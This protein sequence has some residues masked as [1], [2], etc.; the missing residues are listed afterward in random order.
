MLAITKKNSL[1]LSPLFELN[2][3]PFNDPTAPSLSVQDPCNLVKTCT[4]LVKIHKIFVSKN[5]TSYLVVLT[6]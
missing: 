5:V 4:S 2:N 1:G 6:P 3:T